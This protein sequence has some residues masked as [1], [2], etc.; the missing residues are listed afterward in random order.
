MPNNLLLSVQSK[1]TAYV[2]KQVTN[3][4]AI[5]TLPSRC[6]AYN[7]TGYMTN[8]QPYLCHCVIYFAGLLRVLRS[9]GYR[10][11]HWKRVG[12]GCYRV[13]AATYISTR[14]GYI[15]KIF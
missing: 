12:C 4:F 8:I 15:F 11:K 10:G 9:G 14:R 3:L 13:K 5:L 6:S 1:A 7:P 2:P